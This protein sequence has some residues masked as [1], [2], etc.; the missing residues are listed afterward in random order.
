M[1]GNVALR[2]PTGAEEIV[3]L[4]GR[5]GRLLVI[6]A[7]RTGRTRRRVVRIVVRIGSGR[8]F[9]ARTGRFVRMARMIGCRR[10]RAFLRVRNYE[11]HQA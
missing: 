1:T 3:G 6:A 7:V 2:D 10:R 9:V 8:L 5:L 4:H 11:L